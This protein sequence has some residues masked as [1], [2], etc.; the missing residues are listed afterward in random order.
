MLVMLAGTAGAAAARPSTDTRASHV[1][2]LGLPPQVFQGQ[3]VSFKILASPTSRNCTLVIHYKGGRVQRLAARSAASGAT[4]WTA[5]IPAAPP[6]SATLK[7]VCAGAGTATASLS[8]KWALEAPKLVVER[9]GFSQR[10]HKYDAGSDVNFGLA[11]QNE[12][13][14]FDAANVAILVNLVDATNRVLGSAHLSKSRVPAAT[15]IYLGSQMTIPSQTAV[16]RIEVVFVSATSSERQSSVPLLISDTVLVPDTQ[17][18]VSAARGQLLN[19]YPQPL[20]LGDVGVLLEDS[21]GNVI[22]GGSGYASG[23]LSLGAREAF[24]VTGPFSAVPFAQVAAAL[25]TVVPSYTA[26]PQ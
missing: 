8:V 14:H 26:P 18:F 23:P 7:A 15:T 9:R 3:R 2:F 24:G 13:A 21:N 12:R 20:Q 16:T 17:G 5:R 6:G 19:K 4:S 25:F 22:G 1:S 11:I 10:P